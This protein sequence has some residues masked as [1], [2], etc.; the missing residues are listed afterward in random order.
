MDDRMVKMSGPILSS[1]GKAAV[2]SFL[3]LLVGSF[4]LH[5]ELAGSFHDG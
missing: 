5:S 1:R 2:A 4:G 3:V